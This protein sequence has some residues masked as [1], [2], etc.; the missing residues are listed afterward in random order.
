MSSETKI[1]KNCQQNFTIEP[2]E[3]AFHEKMQVPSPTWCPQCR[4][5]R[6]MLFFNERSL[7]KRTCDLC[8]KEVISNHPPSAKPP[9]YCQPCWW[10]DKWDSLDFGREYDVSRKFFEQ[11]QELMDTVPLPAL[12]TIY[13][14]NV[15]SEYVNYC[16]YVKNCYLCFNSDFDEE[17]SFSCYLEQ[18]KRCYDVDHGL[19]D[20]LCYDSMGLY[21]C[22]NVKYSANLDEC[23]DV[24]FSRDL[25]G[26]TNC[27]GCIN[28]R[29][30]QYCWFN[31]QLTKEQYQEKLKQY[32]L[33]DY[34]TVQKIK[35]ETEAFFLTQPHRY[36]TG[37]GNKDA[38]GDYLFWCKNVHQSYDM[39]GVEDA[40]HC[41]FFIIEGAK[42]CMDVTMWGSSLMDAYECCGVGNNQNTIKFCF[43]SWNEASNLTYCRLIYASCFDLFGCISMRNKK[44]C[45]LNKQYSREE[46]FAKITSIKQQ[47]TNDGEYGEFFPPALSMYGYNESFANK[48]L[49][50]TKEEALAKGYRWSEPEKREYTI[51]GDVI[52][53]EHDGKCNQQCSTAFK[54]TPN[55]K[56][57]Y[58]NLGIPT[59]HLCPN[60]RHYERLKLRNRVTLHSRTCG[61]C[62]KSMETS[63]A[64]ER[65][66]IVYC[67]SCYNAEIL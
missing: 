35:K 22:Y 33:S 36:V 14:S 6:R 24:F 56:D 37:I 32:D 38:S 31:E 41:Q 17:C 21:K 26:C 8:G 19:L 23:I 2:D 50:L 51:G 11:F 52:A 16:S 5:A 48:Y 42:N 13:T 3:A 34:D 49:P 60:C 63:Y 47:M 67:E 57:F 58:K 61:K 46:Y 62:G 20:E 7:Y 54:L 64:P 39:V 30:K 29:N 27:F 53:C 25:K 65:K 9:I 43:D 15:N 66:E 1:C 40:K 55:E 18:S 12:N 44:Y 45:I 4:M 59:P 28:L 10:S